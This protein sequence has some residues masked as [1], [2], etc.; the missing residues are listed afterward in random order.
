MKSI[1]IGDRVP[2]VTFTVQDGR[3]ISISDLKGRVVVLFFY[4]ADDTLVC[5]REACSFR[6]A[7]P[8]FQA[9]GAL[10]IGVSGDSQRTHERFAASQRLPYLLACDSD[11]SL[12]RAFGVSKQ[13]GLLARRITYVIDRE[14][15]VRD[16]FESQFRPRKHVENALRVVRALELQRQSN[17]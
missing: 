17:P 7:F 14:G 1:R 6:D 15:I 12:R 8:G 9:S 13:F 4:P 11:E 2:E 10:V 3:R 16:V 5:T